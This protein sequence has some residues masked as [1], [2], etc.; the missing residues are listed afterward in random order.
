LIEIKKENMYKLI[1]VFAIIIC[2]FVYQ[3]SAQNKSTDSLKQQRVYYQEPNWQPRAILPY[4]DAINNDFWPASPKVETDYNDPDFEEA[5]LSKVPAPGIYP[6]VLITP[7]DVERIQAKIALGDKAPKAFKVMWQRVS[8]IKTPFY[9][10]VTNNDTLGRKLAVELVSKIKSLES[11]IDE[12]NKRPDSEN[13]WA[14][15]R[16]IIASG[17]PNPPVEIWDLLEYDYLHKWMTNDERELA[18]RVIAKVIKNRISNFLMVPDHFMINNHEGFGMEYL[19]LMLLI[20]GQEGFDKKLFNL[21]VHKANAML[22]WFL[23]KDGMC[24]ESIKGWLNTSAMVA[25]GL[26][27][28]DLLKHGHLRAKINFFL[29]ATRWENNEWHIRDEMRASAFHVIWMMRYYHPT[30]QRLDFLYQSTFTTHPF[31]NDASVKWPDPVG[32]CYELLLLYAEDGMVDNSG[33]NIDWKSQAMIDRLQ[34]PTT[35]HDS[36]RGYVEVRNSWRKDDLKVGFV[37]KQDFFYGGH[38][39]SE[40]N[41]LTLWK[42]GVNWIQDNNM[43]ATKATFLQNMLT[44][45]GK[46][47]HWPPVAGNWLGIKENKQSLMA[48]GDGK[49]GYSFTKIMQVHPLYFPSAKLP[50]YKPFTEGNF[51]LS[52]DIQVAFQPSTIA[53]NNGYAHT[54]YGP[55]S[56]ETRLVEGYKPFN[57]VQKA[58]RTIQVAKG[59]YPYLL[60]ID[61]VQKDNQLHHYDWNISV[62][63]Q[64]T[65]V[66]VK[67]PEIVFQNTEPSNERTDDLIIASRPIAKDSLGKPMLQK[68]EPLCLI[69]VLWRNTEYGFGVPSLQQFEGY[70]LINIPA[71]AVSPDF[72]VLVYPYKYGEPLP[73]TEWNKDKTQLTLTVKEQKDVYQFALGDG[74]RTALQMNRKSEHVA[75]NEVLPSKPVL[76][77]RNTRCNASDSRYTRDANVLPVYVVNSTASILFQYPD[78][79]AKVHYT[80]DGTEPNASSAVFIKPII[81]DKNCTLK[82]KT[83]YDAWP[84]ASTTSSETVTAYFKKQIPS[85]GLA[86]LPLANKQGLGLKLYEINTKSYN[87]KGFFDADKIMMPD[88]KQ[89][90]ASYDVLSDGFNIPYLSPTKPLEQQVKGFYEF[91]GFWYAKETGVYKFNINSCGPV[92]FDIDKQSVVSSVGIFHQQQAIRSGEIVLAKGWHAIELI[93]CDPLFWNANSLDIMPLQV[94]YQ[95]DGN[96]EIIIQP[97]D[98]RTSSKQVV[99]NDMPSLSAITNTTLLEKGFDLQVYD[100]TGKRRD[101]DFMDIDGLEPFI[102]ERSSVL[103]AASSKNSVRVYNGYYFASTT[104]IYQFQMPLRQGDNAGLGGTQASCQ[105]LIKIDE[106][107]VLQRGVYGRHL[108]G[109]VLLKEGWHKVSIRLGTGLA[110]CS[111]IL[112]SGQ[113]VAIDANNVYRAAQVDILPNGE[114]YHQKLYELYDSVQVKLAFKNATSN[115]LRYTLD[116][117]V[118]NAQSSIY[119]NSITILKSCVLQVV[120]FNNSQPLTTVTKMIFQKVTVPTRG[121]LGVLRFDNWDGK[122]SYYSSGTS[123]KVWLDANASLTAGI[124]GKAISFA[125][126]ESAFKNVDVNVSRGTTKAACKLYDVNMKENALTVSIWFKTNDTN[127]KL[128]EKDGYNAF[129]KRYK[130]I[131]CTINNGKYYALGNKLS[132]GQVE[133]NTWQHIVL[134]SSEDG[135][136]LYLNGKPIAKAAGT[137]DIT[138]DAL[139][140][141]TSMNVT[142]DQ[143]QLFD[144][145]LNVKEIER[146]FKNNQQ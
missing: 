13:I 7:T 131:S 9:A 126:T 23:D 123:Y 138:T 24:Y 118:P 54:D 2:V 58:Y 99:V 30:N 52:R 97:N 45:D 14:V 92:T 26:R 134:A 122:N 88:V 83:I 74:G 8:T 105:S 106:A 144:R 69:R 132:G 12:M 140:F 143:I 91:T 76:I 70:S 3:A 102:H 39:G 127:G 43:L 50:Y 48:S 137:K 103:E 71:H 53:W 27:K 135:V 63:V 81:I 68:G 87:D 109:K 111:V 41:R 65:L 56:G 60:V 6:R 10:L 73:I 49:I 4:K 95:L 5:R 67:T 79:G 125:P 66:E 117:S 130:T 90:K 115:V 32:V 61:D 121:S 38:E 100:R 25:V 114:A 37:C 112:P 64:A 31:L 46:G 11:K 116:G 40:N 120:A 145:Y 133:P 84:F 104:G 17:E 15:E 62:P 47:L 77:V 136:V 141:F 51:D 28:R 21:A 124:K 33:K 57:E 139:N 42:D 85:S 29:T 55:W 86:Q 98:L 142:I 20:E 129:G 96:D 19:R 119:S 34:L 128:F 93:V 101:R 113:V 107:Y 59:K 89:Y 72:K 22:D 44:I 146:L 75:N 78:N 36:T 1:G 16:S 82:A 94:S 80:L 108:S 18:R 110:K 35:W